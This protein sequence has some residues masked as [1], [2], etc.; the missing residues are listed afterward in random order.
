[1]IVG[2]GIAG[3]TAAALLSQCSQQQRLKITVLDAGPRPVFNDADPVSLRV[4]AIATGSADLLASIGAWDS[5]ADARACAYDAMRVWDE[6]SVAESG[7]TLRFDAAEFA[8]SQL[9]F[10]VENSLVQHAIL[11]VLDG[12]GVELVFD[13]PIR[14]MERGDGQY[15]L[16]LEDGEEWLADLVIG[17]DG[18]RSFVRAAMDIETRDHAYGQEAVVAHLQPERPHNNTAWQRFLHDGPLGLLPLADGRVSIVWSTSVANARRAME[19]PDA[20]FGTLLTEASDRVLGRLELSSAR[21]AFPLLA[22]HAER[23]VLPGVALIG[24]AAHAIHPLAGQGANLGLQDAAR[25]AEV[26][27]EAL[28]NDEH[29]GDRPVLRRYERARRGANASM[30]HLMTALNQL[31]RTDS[32]LLKELRLTG[33]RLFNFSGPIREQAVRVALGV[34]R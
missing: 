29:P 34:R 26:I 12:S 8:V 33:M 2:A 9:G 3:L 6:N 30:L 28:C 18:A 17:A 27:D 32:V 23:Y 4:S 15:S 20:D 14:A 31:F 22:R 11:D 5:I 13:A 7:A 16:R 21:A 10:I 1:V 25:L 24:D 19:V